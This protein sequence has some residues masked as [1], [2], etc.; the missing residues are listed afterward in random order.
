MVSPSAEKMKEQQRR[1]GLEGKEGKRGKDPT[2][3][4]LVYF[5]ARG[6][7]KRKQEG[8]IRRERKREGGG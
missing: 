2:Q 3:S 5:W 6:Q 7:R 1:L 8:A 4:I